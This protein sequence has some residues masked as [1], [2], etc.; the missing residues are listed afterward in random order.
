M[1]MPMAETGAP[2]GGAAQVK[3]STTV[4]E[5]ILALKNAPQDIKQWWSNLCGV[6]PKSFLILIASVYFCQGLGGFPSLVTK[7]YLKYSVHKNCPSCCIGGD[8]G[9]CGP[10]DEL[11]WNTDHPDVPWMSNCHIGLGMVPSA[12]QDLLAMAGLPWNYKVFYGMMSDALP[13]KG[14]NRRSYIFLAG[15]LGV[16]G[17]IGLGSCGDMA[18]PSTVLWFLFMTQLSTAFCDVCTDALVAENAKLESESGAGNLQSLCWCALGVGGILSSMCA[19]YVYEALD[20]RL[21]FFI[22]ALIPGARLVLAARLKEG[23]KSSV[24]MGKI[25]SQGRKLWQTLGHPGI[26]R[27]IGFIFL[28]WATIPDLS[29]PQFNYLTA[30]DNSQWEATHASTGKTVLTSDFAK[31]LAGN[32]TL[33]CGWFKHNDAGCMGEWM[34]S[35]VDTDTSAMDTVGTV[36]VAGRDH[37]VLVPADYS[38]AYAK[39]NCTMSKCNCQYQTSTGDDPDQCSVLSKNPTPGLSPSTLLEACPLFASAA[40]KYDTCGSKVYDWAHIPGLPK[41]T[42]VYDICPEIC[43]GYLK[44]DHRAPSVD[45][46]G[47]V[48]GDGSTCAA[49]VLAQAWMQCPQACQECELNKRGCLGFSSNFM[50]QLGVIGYAGLLAGSAIFSAYF[51]KTPYR[52]LLMGCQLVLCAFS[53]LDWLALAAVNA[54]DGTVMGIDGHVFAIFNEVANDVMY[55]I[56][57]MPMLVL[58]AQICPANIEGTL[59]AFIMQMSN[60]GG[61]YA[62]FFGVW[63]TD[64]LAIT[65]LDFV[66]LQTGQILRVMFKLS[67]ILYLFLVPDDNPKD[68][69]RQIDAELCAS[70]N[71]MRIDSPHPCALAVCF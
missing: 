10:D 2:V 23:A 67:P 37:T 63:F 33:T 66:G 29:T 40:Y 48:R 12:Q 13:I 54:E 26:H 16:A 27:P 7:Y 3:A 55:Q 35:L 41:N 30:L 32:E 69:I 39:T 1:D 71:P 38:N 60:T 18:A 15:V 51:K 68:V 24:D 34:D 5:K 64:A 53:V 17:F 56:K 50:S 47:V 11:A 22:S 45:A 43:Q 36:V 65:D 49:A 31:T 28:S 42:M 57:L 6:F 58:A 46:C 8:C 44:G 14:S 9:A 52:K 20:A 4:V 59:F 21:C 70:G 62:A 19:G 25:K 61:S